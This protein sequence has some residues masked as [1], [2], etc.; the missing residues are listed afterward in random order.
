MSK[1]RMSWSRGTTQVQAG[2]YPESTVTVTQH[3]AEGGAFTIHRSGRMAYRRNAG[4]RGSWSNQWCWTGYT[5]TDN[6]PTRHTWHSRT[7]R[8]HTVAQA[9]REAAHRVAEYRMAQLTPNPA[10][11]GK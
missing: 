11:E 6:R 7:A 9:K 1:E 8:F 5:L 10:Q 3:V 4:A 2:E